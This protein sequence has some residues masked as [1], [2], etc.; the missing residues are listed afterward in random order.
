[1]LAPHITRM[2]KISSRFFYLSHYPF[3]TFVFL[4]RNLDAGSLKIYGFVLNGGISRIGQELWR[5]ITNVLLQRSFLFHRPFG[6]NR[7]NT[8]ILL[9]P[10]KCKCS[11]GLLNFHR[12][13]LKGGFSRNGSRNVHGSHPVFSPR[14]F[15]FQYMQNI[16][17]MFEY[18]TCRS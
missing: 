10:F 9:K 6:R 15:V 18:V 2:F 5:F 4:N 8:C 12:S 14:F 13:L 17:V 7:F 3:G 1:M 16:N 11:R